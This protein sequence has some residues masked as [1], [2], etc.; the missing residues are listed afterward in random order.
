M[1]TVTP[2]MNLILFSRKIVANG[3]FDSTT[4]SFGDMQKIDNLTA[5]Q[6]KP[7]QLYFSGGGLYKLIKPLPK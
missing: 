7:S 1:T 5:P 2:K 4:A 6:A 3:I